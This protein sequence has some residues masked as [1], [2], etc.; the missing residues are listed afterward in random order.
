VSVG[1]VRFHPL[2]Q[3][4]QHRDIAPVDADQ[5]LVLVVRPMT[6]LSC[7]ASIAMR[8]SIGAALTSASSDKLMPAR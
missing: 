7:G 3:P 4:F 6:T 8:G 5:H 1:P 2:D